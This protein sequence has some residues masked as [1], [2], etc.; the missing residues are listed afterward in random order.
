MPFPGLAAGRGQGPRRGCHVGPWA[1]AFHLPLWGPHHT[2]PWGR[3]TVIKTGK[4]AGRGCA[5]LGEHTAS[6]KRAATPQLQLA[7]V[8]QWTLFPGLVLYVKSYF[9]EVGKDVRERRGGGS[10]NS[11][12]WRGHPGTYQ[13]GHPLEEVDALPIIDVVRLP[14]LWETGGERGSQAPAYLRTPPFGWLPQQ[15]P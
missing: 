10:P 1:V 4:L 12:C 11:H 15:L 13:R 5:K 7:P 14:A 2:V 3:A 8:T 6:P 9:L